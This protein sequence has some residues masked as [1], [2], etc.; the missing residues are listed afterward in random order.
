[1]ARWI[2]AF[3]CLITLSLMLPLGNTAEA[4]GVTRAAARQIRCTAP[5]MFLMRTPTTWVC[6]VGQ[7]C[8]YDKLL[9][10]GTCIAASD[11]CF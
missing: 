5:A 7:K 4:D 8:C 11:R 9:R 3:V 6:R 1:M 2:I 10:K